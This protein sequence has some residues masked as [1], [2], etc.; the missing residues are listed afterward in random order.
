MSPR[1]AYLPLRDECRVDLRS[2]LRRRDVG[3]AAV[4]RA[5]VEEKHVARRHLGREHCVV[6]EHGGALL[7]GA[8]PAGGAVAGLVW[9]ATKRSEWKTKRVRD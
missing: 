2:T 1:K 3:A 5:Q 8:A 9:F 4:Q 7:R 6:V